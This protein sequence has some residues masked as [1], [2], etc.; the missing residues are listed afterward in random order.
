MCK[1]LRWQWWQPGIGAKMMK[2]FHMSPPSRPHLIYLDEPTNHLDMETIDA[3]VE[4]IKEFQG[5]V[6]MVSWLS[7]CKSRL[8]F[9]ESSVVGFWSWGEP[10]PVL[11]LPSCHTIL[12]RRGWQIDGHMAK[13]TSFTPLVGIIYLCIYDMWHHTIWIL[14]IEDFDCQVL[15]LVGLSWFGRCQSCHLRYL[16]CN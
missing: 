8:P 16:S 10:W 5:A 11:P 4:A 14:L 3:L 6:V 15:I 12:V 13:K 2:D 7:C 1:I 9:F